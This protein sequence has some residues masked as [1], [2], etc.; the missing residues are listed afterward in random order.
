METTT[1]VP[2][3]FLDFGTSEVTH[4]SSDTTHVRIRTIYAVPKFKNTYRGTYPDS[5]FLLTVECLDCLER[6]ALFV[7]AGY[8][9]DQ[10]LVIRADYDVVG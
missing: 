4:R 5:L 2:L 9:V 1:K 3:R 6:Y 10:R 8:R 7:H